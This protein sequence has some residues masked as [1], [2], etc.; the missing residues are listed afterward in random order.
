MDQQG[1]DCEVAPPAVVLVSAALT[2]VAQA[3][4]DCIHV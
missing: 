2:S 1:K 4:A 3:K